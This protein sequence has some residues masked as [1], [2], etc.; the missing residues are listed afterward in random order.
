MPYL[1]KRA[2]EQTHRPKS[3]ND[4]A[5]LTKWNHLGNCKLESTLGLDSWVLYDRH[6]WQAS[7]HSCI[8]RLGYK[9]CQNDLHDAMPAVHIV[10]AMC[11]NWLK[12]Q[13]DNTCTFTKTRA[14][15]SRHS[16][17]IIIVS[18]CTLQQH[19]IAC[20]PNTNQKLQNPTR[21][22]KV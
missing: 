19:S 16:M 10:L 2:T 18:E 20:K 5:S 4:Y 14:T 9:A 6:C 11:T 13:L 15:C 12:V 17:A 8:Q 1:R 3:K 7:H 21:L 22:N